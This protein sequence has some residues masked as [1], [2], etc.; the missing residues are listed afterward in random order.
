MKH[1]YIVSY[2]VSDAK[3]LRLVF[4]LMKGWGLHVQY[5]VFQCDLNPT[6]VTEL[7]S[8]L[9]D[10]IEPSLDQFLFINLGPTEGR[11]RDAIAS[12][13]R[14]YSFPVRVPIIA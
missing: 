13:G 2:D 7:Q 1:T 12:L 14:P 10:I 11:A 6:N 3:R 8:A 4:K 9:E 5:S